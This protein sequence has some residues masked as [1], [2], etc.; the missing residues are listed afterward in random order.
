MQKCNA[1]KGPRVEML[2]QNERNEIYDE[3]IFQELSERFEHGTL[4]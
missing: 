1:R 2:Q 4:I 3:G